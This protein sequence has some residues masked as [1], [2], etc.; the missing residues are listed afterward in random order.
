MDDIR[1]ADIQDASRSAEISIFTKRM[2]Y[3]EIFHND[4][5]SFGEMQVYPLAKDLIDHPE[6]LKDIWVYDDGFVK[7]MIHIE[8]RR[9]LELYVDYFFQN[10]GIGTKLIRYAI[11]STQQMVQLI[12]L[13]MHKTAIPVL[14]IERHPRFFQGGNGL[15]ERHDLSICGIWD[16]SAARI[17]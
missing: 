12:L 10:E 15:C 7:G 1:K 8:K 14:L 5:V 4:K 11:Q 3:R 16:R 13:I 9:I 2:D 6:K 17:L